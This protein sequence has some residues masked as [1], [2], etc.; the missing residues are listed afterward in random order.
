MVQHVCGTDNRS[1]THTSEQNLLSF[2]STTPLREIP[3]KFMTNLEWMHGLAV[4]LVGFQQLGR[5]AHQRPKKHCDDDQHRAAI[6][7]P[8][9]LPQT[10]PFAH[11]RSRRWCRRRCRFDVLMMFL[12]TGKSGTAGSLVLIHFRCIVAFP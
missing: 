10:T 8:D 4:S 11:G 2:S 7:G 3:K 9:A 1:D 6:P 12:D 5:K